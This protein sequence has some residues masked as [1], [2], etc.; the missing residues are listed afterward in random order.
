MLFRS[1]LPKD[2]RGVP[3]EESTREALALLSRFGLEGFERDYP[4]ALSGGMRQ[5]AALLRTWLTGCET[6]TGTVGLAGPRIAE[7]ETPDAS[8]TDNIGSLT[9]VVRRNPNS[10]EPYNTRGSAYA[11]AGRYQEAITDFTQAIRI[12]QN[13]AAAY[14]NRALAYRQTNRNDQALAD[15]GRAI[16]AEIGRAHV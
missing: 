11:R 3:R 1:V 7:V 13:Y 9:E 16:T 2:I 10:A 4:S 15:F 12:D 8:F 5:R 6:T 14:I